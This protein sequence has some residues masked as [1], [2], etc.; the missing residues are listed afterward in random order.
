SAG[1]RWAWRSAR[2]G[3]CWREGLERREGLRTP[4]LLEPL[5][6]G[7]FPGLAPA[8]LRHGFG[9]LAPG[10]EMDLHTLA[11]RELPA[12]SRSEL[13]IVVAPAEAAGDGEVPTSRS[14]ALRTRA[15]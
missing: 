13:L 12:H 2:R 3:C 4:A 15:R 5:L 11:I 8:R 6:R 10:P 9:E 1:W 14:R 7:C